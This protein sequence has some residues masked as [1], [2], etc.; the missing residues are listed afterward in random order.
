MST[1]VDDRGPRFNLSQGSW[2]L[3]WSHVHRVLMV[4]LVGAV[5]SLP[6]LLAL[7]AEPRPWQYPVLLTLL[8]FGAGPTLAAVF[9]YLRLTVEEERVPATEAFRCYRRLFRPALLTWSP[10]ATLAAVGLTDLVVLSGT[11]AGAALAPLLGVVVLITVSS[12][13]TA[14]AAL[15]D[16]RR[17]TVRRT[18]LAASYA[19]VRRW[20]FALA[21]LGLL[22]ATLMIVNQAPLLGLAVVP[23]C[24]LFVVWRNCRAMLAFDPH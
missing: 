11:A 14:M 10:F 20:P 4:N 18:L 17:A 22:G 8:S 21:N 7:S 24:A 16:G 3:I 1:R 2:D 15:P 23:G 5:T 12:G 6:L 19:S 9:A 13:I